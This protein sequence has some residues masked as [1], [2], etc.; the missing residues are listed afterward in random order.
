M[1]VRTKVSAAA[2][3]RPPP[4]RSPQLLAQRRTADRL[5]GDMSRLINRFP[6]RNSQPTM[7][8]QPNLRTQLITGKF[9][10]RVHMHVRGAPPWRP[11][12]LMNDDQNYIPA[13]I[14]LRDGLG[15][16]EFK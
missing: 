16:K 7:N 12:G 13:K 8:E 10:L 2:G 5:F 1:H 9:Q 14:N 15:R 3:A 6:V 4:Y 11:G